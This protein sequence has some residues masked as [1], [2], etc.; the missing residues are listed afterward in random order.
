MIQ[1]VVSEFFMQEPQ[2]L[3]EKRAIL[4]RILTRAKQKFN[5]SIAE[6]DFQDL[7]QRTEISFAVVSSSHIQA[8]KETRE[9]LAFLDSFPEW[10]RAE[11]VMEKL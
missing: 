5:V 11:T 8:E 2:N 9:V 3:K 6:T 10:E 4:K 7:W 1:S